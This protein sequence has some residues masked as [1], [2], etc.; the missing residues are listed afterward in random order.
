MEITKTD[1]KLLIPFLVYLIV[2]IYSSHIYNYIDSQKALRLTFNWF[3]VPSIISGF[4]YSY[5]S[6]FQRGAQQALWR[7]AAGLLALT[8]IFTLLFLTSSQGYVILWNANFG[9]QDKIMLQGKVTKLDYP[10]GKKPLN[11]YAIFI[12]I[13]NTNKSISLNVPSNKYVVGHIFKKK[14]IKGSLGILYAQ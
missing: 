13:N 1:L 14:M 3:T 5:Y 10:K 4:I 6:I 7:K 12:N 9:K 8:S 11:S 2:G